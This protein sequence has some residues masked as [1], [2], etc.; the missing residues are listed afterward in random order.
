MRVVHEEEEKEDHFKVQMCTFV[1]KFIEM[2]L[3]FC[4]LNT[5]DVKYVVRYANSYVG[6]WM[7]DIIICYAHYG[8]G[9]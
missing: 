3:C 6:W 2:Y 8:W 4:A 5:A 1:Q 9:C 7:T